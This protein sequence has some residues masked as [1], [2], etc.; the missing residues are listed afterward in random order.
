VR[1]S[2]IALIA[3]ASGRLMLAAALAAF[4]LQSWLMAPMSFVMAALAATDGLGAVLCGDHAG[5]TSEPTRQAPVHAHDQ[6][7]QC[8]A[9]AAIA[10][11]VPPPAV[12]PPSIVAAVVY[13][14]PGADLGFGRIAAYAPRGP[15]A[16][17]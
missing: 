12:V 6:C 11:A 10:L 1:P 15:P 8:P 7:L 17:A 4:V 13:S 9:A 14:S 16:R 2:R 5:A 3:T